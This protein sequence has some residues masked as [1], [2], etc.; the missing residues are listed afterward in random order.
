MRAHAERKLLPSLQLLAHIADHAFELGVLRRFLQSG[1][2]T[3][4][5]DAGF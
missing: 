2:R 3:H 4:D 5:R 1:K